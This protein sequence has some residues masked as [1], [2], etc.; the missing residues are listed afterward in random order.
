MMHGI[1][2]FDAVENVFDG[3]V[4]GVL[5][6]LDRQTLVPHIL[7]RNDLGA[8]LLLRELF[9]GDV[10]VFEVI[11]AVNAAVDAVVGQIQ[12]REHH[13]AV[14][15]KRLLDL[16]GQAVDLLVLFGNVARQQHR[17][18][19]VG[20]PRAGAAV[21]VLFGARFFEQLVNERGVVLVLVR[22]SDGCQYFFMVDEFLRM[23]GFGI[24][25]CHF[26]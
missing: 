5:A 16:V 6:R 24:I 2:G 11:R 25:S 14:A 23:E 12:R 21:A 26:L 18:L 7:Q 8:H 20:Q 17:R 4:H 3:V 13:D 19:A 15:V 9:A 10:L 22:V 1:D